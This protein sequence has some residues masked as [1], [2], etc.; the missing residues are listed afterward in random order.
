[1]PGQTAAA[2]KDF[3]QTLFFALG[4]VLLVSEQSLGQADLDDRPTYAELSAAQHTAEAIARGR[5][6]EGLLPILELYRNWDRVDPAITRRELERLATERRLPSLL[7]AYVGALLAR[8]DI[9]DGAVEVANERIRD[10]GYVT[11]FRMVGPFDNEGKRGYAR[12]YGPEREPAEPP[13]L[14]A[15]F[16]GKDREVSWRPMPKR[17]LLGYVDLDAPMRPN[18]DV[19]G[20]AETV[21]HSDRARPLTLWFGGGGAFRMYWNGREVLSDNGY[22]SF[23]DPDRQV[24]TAFA[25]AGPNRLLIKSCVAAT[26]WGFFLRI[27]DARGAPTSGWSA[28]AQSAPPISMQPQGR[29]PAAPATP[30]RALEEAANLENAKAGAFF[31]LARFLAYTGADDPAEHRAYQLARRAFDLEPTVKHAALAARLATHRGQQTVLAERALRLEPNSPE[32]AL[33]NAQVHMGSPSPE[34]ALPW[35]DQIHDQAP[36]A[37]D[38]AILRSEIYHRLELGNTALATL[39]QALEVQPNS[40]LLLEAAADRAATAGRSDRAIALRKRVVAVRYDAVESRRALIS[41]A[42]HRGESAIVEQHIDALRKLTPASSTEFRYLARVYESLGNTSEALELLSAALQIAPFDAETWV[43]EGRLLLRSGRSDAAANAL[44]RALTIR[45]QDPGTRELLEQLRPEPRED[46]AYKIGMEALLARKHT[47][48]SAADTEYPSTI[49]QNLTVNTVYENGLS[50]SFR[51]IAA[52]I[53]DD[54]GARQ[55]RTYSIPFEPGS[56]RV[57][58]REAR[59]LRSNGEVLESLRIFEQPL[60]EPWYRIYYDTRALVVAFP[61]LSAGDVIEI[62]YRLDDIAHRNLFADY[63]GDLHF[64]GGV[65][66][67]QHVDYVLITPSSRN[68]YFN[69]PDLPGLEHRQHIEDGT[70]IDHFRAS[71]IPALK[72]EEGMPGRTEVA[73]FLHVSTYLNWADVGRWYWGLVKDQL[74]ADESLKRT[75]QE[76]VGDTEDL[77]LRVQRIQHWVVQNTRYVGLEFGIHGYKP[78]RV[79][80]IVQRGFGDCKD[81]ASLLVTML[82]EA[83][84]EAELVLVRTRRNGEIDP[85]PASLAIFD[86]AIAYVPALELYIDGTAEHSGMRELPQMDQGVAVLHVGPAGAELRRSPVLGPQHN[87]RERQMHIRLDADGAA[88]VSVSEEIVGAQA[89]SM[90]H[91][92][93]AEGSRSERWERAMRSLFPGLNLTRVDMEGTGDLEGPIKVRYEAIVPQLATQD[94]ETL[95]MPLSVLGDLSASLARVRQRTHPLDLGGTSHYAEIRTV[96]LPSSSE[97]TELPEA[98]VAQ[99]VFGSLTLE[100]EKTDELIETRV[101]LIIAR[102]RISSAEYPAFRTWIES[103]DRLLRQRVAIEM[104]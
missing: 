6:A 54:E 61:D 73:P 30:L 36:Q 2:P 66:P 48:L 34:D 33:L 84:I 16:R 74:Y 56:E 103:A 98:G 53:H 35:L 41:D 38:A 39:E 22:R 13:D 47:T 51:Q 89:S 12:I 104:H 8:A 95:R 83:G 37:L 1:M 62:Q 68:F 99:S 20:Y 72:P 75:V 55:W 49:L 14:R 3:V 86:H 69:S 59:V 101:E 92:Y 24:A 79:P 19:C 40:R 7:R 42:L 64:L 23:P 17:A 27:G 43:A 9:R 71:Q 25:N 58:V 90:R 26:T 102:D 28:D 77:S 81:K 4:L 44:R 70:R 10:L 60:G 18:A 31:D 21:I 93:Q 80:E 46:E 97:I 85:L 65:H 76:L 100:V 78:Y 57:E 94:G 82:R 15:S 11:S 52:Q 32:T 5:R 67:T 88:Q 96:H 87:R 45:P 29:V 63:Y 50:S 91:R